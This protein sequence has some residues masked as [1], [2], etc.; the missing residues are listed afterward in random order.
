MSEPLILSCHVCGAGA[1]RTQETQDPE[2]LAK[3]VRIE[4]Y[5][6]VRDECRRKIMVIYEPA[7]GLDEEQR[8]WVERE[9]MR[10]GAFF[11]AD[12]AP[13]MLRR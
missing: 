11:P 6:C 12:H 2:G 5:Q 9:V 8:T 13:G 10:A 7:G 4:A 1:E 3:G